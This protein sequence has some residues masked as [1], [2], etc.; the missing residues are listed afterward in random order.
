ML[1]TRGSGK[2]TISQQNKGDKVPRVHTT[3]PISKKAYAGSLPLTPAAARNQRTH[4]CYECGSLRHYKSECP[5][6]KFQN[7]VDMIHGRVMASKPKTM[8]DATKFATKLMDKKIRT[9]AECQ[10]KNK[11]PKNRRRNI[12]ADLSRCVLNE[13]ITMMVHVLLN[14]TSA[15]KLAIWPVTVGALQMPILLTT[16]EALGQVRRLL[17]MNMGIKGTTREIARS[18]RT[19]NYEN[20][21]G[22][23]GARGVV[24]AL[25][26]G[27]TDQYPNNIEDEIK[28]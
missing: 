21:I 24:H 5:I 6:I 3:R 18:E 25:R 26:G 10:A 4:T 16:K 14:A 15:T 22:G 11:N 9:L 28:A 23:T 19:K 27:E 17:A 12:M 20:Q 1:A 7:C 2:V 8:Q 13:T